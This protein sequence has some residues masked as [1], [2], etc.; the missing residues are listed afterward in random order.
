V[1][2]RLWLII[3]F[4]FGS[5]SLIRVSLVSDSLLLPRPK[6]TQ[7]LPSCFTSFNSNALLSLVLKPSQRIRA[8]INSTTTNETSFL[9][10]CLKGTISAGSVAKFDRRGPAQLTNPCFQYS[11]VFRVNRGKAQTHSHAELRI[12]YFGVPIDRLSRRMRIFCAGISRERAEGIDIS[13]MRAPIRARECA[14]KASASA[15]KF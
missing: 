1:S 6:K 5:L 4:E 9:A 3:T 2:A 8:M 13:E 12:N 14:S 15:V 7:D 11:A 10:T